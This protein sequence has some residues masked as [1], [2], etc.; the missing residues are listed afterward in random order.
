MSEKAKIAVLFGGKSTEYD[1]S[2]TSAS[3]VLRAMD[4]E[5]YDIFPIGISREGAWFYYQGEISDIADDTWQNDKCNLFPVLLNLSPTKKGFLCLGTSKVPNFFLPIDFAFPI[6]HGKNGE[7]GTVQGAFEAAQIPV[8]GCG[9]LSSALC[10]DKDRSHRLAELAGIKTPRAVS[11]TKKTYKEALREIRQTLS[12]PLFVKPVRSGSSIGISKI[13]IEA[14]LEP[15]L[16]HAFLYDSEV[17]VEEEITGCEVG[18]AVMGTDELTIGRVDEIEI[19]S[20]FFD[21]H[22]KYTLETS[23]IHMPARI[24]AATEERIKETAAKIYRVLHCSGFARVDMF[25]TTDGEIVFNEVNTI[26]GMT[27]HSRFPNMMQGIGLN[28]AQMID[29]LIALYTQA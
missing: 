15:A 19:S 22:E 1:V 10:M 6:L 28:F 26:P 7:D 13:A 4:A 2:L 20:G 9:T 8:I 16:L 25:L 27:S 23:D 12:Y 29:K 18:C 21:Y 17:I 3:A 11:F 5:K 24:D 14:E